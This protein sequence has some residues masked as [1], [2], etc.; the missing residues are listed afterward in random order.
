MKFILELIFE[1]VYFGKLE[2]SLAEVRSG[3]VWFC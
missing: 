2:F 1:K 3:Q